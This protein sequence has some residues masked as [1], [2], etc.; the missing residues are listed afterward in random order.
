MGRKLR[1][2]ALSDTHRQHVDYTDLLKAGGGDLLIHTGD[3][4]CFDENTWKTFANWAKKVSSYFEYGMILVPGNHDTYIQEYLEECREDLNG[5]K[6]RLLVNEE[7]T[8]AG[9][10]IYGSPYVQPTGHPRYNAFTANGEHLEELW[11]GFPFGLDLLC[12]HGPASGVLDD[13]LGDPWLFE[14]IRQKKPK[15]HIFG[16]IHEKAGSIQRGETLHV[17]SA[18]LGS[19]VLGPFKPTWIEYDLETRT[20]TASELS[21]MDLR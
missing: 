13:W 6:V 5:T 17:N 3:A 19:F 11:E 1:I 16:H 8:V 15:V 7:I 10:R 21:L 14:A 9:L 20:A 4:D 18:I 2:S 12:T